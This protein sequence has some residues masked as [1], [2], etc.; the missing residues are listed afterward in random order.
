[1]ERACRS[2]IKIILLTFLFLI[3]LLDNTHVGF[4]RDAGSEWASLYQ[5]RAEYAV[6]GNYDQ[7]LIVAKRALDVAQTAVGPEHPDVA[8]CL[9][10]LAFI[11]LL[12]NQYALAEPLCNRAITIYEKALAQ[13]NYGLAD[14]FNILATIYY[15]QKSIL[16][17]SF[18]RSLAICEKSF[19]QNHPAVATNI[20]SLALLYYD[21]RKYTQ[22]EPFLIIYHWKYTSRF[23]A[24]TTSL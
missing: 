13:E 7:A 6:S 1:M 11:Y 10:N 12:K 4:A 18:V 16:K 21:Q 15:K 8:I 24:K 19:G 5:E 20:S 23:L 22:A 2:H 9:N 14:S 3:L 17:S